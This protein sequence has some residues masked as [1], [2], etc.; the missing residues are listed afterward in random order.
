MADGFFLKY[1]IGEQA[2]L[3]L[4]NKYELLNGMVER[5]GDLSAEDKIEVDNMAKL[6]P[7]IGDDMIRGLFCNLIKRITD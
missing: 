6:V 3:F 5:K 4:T 7:C 1:T 2:R